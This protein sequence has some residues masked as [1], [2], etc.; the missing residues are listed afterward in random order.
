MIIV[1]KIMVLT[2]S[3][4]QP[5]NFIYC[6]VISERAFHKPAPVNLPELATGLLKL[7][8]APYHF[9][10]HIKSLHLASHY[11]SF[12][13]FEAVKSTPHTWPCSTLNSPSSAGALSVASQSTTVS[14]PDAF[15]ATSKYIVKG[16]NKGL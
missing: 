6:L 2:E 7:T 13:V 14:F 11:G 4:L 5:I 16:G 9:R 3:P 1:V 10:F 15:S 12:S 8:A